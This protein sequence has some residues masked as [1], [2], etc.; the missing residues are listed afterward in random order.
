MLII[1]LRCTEQ[2]GPA[3]SSHPRDI[4]WKVNNRRRREMGHCHV[5]PIGRAIITRA[6]DDGPALLGRD[7]LVEIRI[8]SHKLFSGAIR[9][10]GLRGNVT[11]RK[12]LA[13][14]M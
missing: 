8:G 14:M 11:L 2:A 5:D 1:A 3:N 9:K 4:S 7:L 10:A 13:E 12:D 6:G